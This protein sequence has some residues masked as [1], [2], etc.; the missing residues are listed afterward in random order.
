MLSDSFYKS[1][2]LMNEAGVAWLLDDITVIPI[3]LSE[4]TEENMQGFINRRI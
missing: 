2:F 3:G 1:S 4:I